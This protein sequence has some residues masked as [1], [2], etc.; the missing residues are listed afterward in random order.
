MG[1]GELGPLWSDYQEKH[2]FLRLPL[3]IVY[4][5]TSSFHRAGTL[6]T[7]RYLY[8][9]IILDYYFYILL[10]FYNFGQKRFEKQLL[11]LAPYIPLYLYQMLTQKLLRAYACVTVK[12]KYHGASGIQDFA[13]SATMLICVVELST[14]YLAIQVGLGLCI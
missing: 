11:N 12:Y 4:F 10:L 2:F 8:K 14:T 3:F 6:A 1:V 7:Q 9:G 13:G 5:Q